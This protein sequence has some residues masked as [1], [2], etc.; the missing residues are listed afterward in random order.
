MLDYYEEYAP[1]KRIHIHG[2]SSI[3][4]PKDNTVLFIKEKYSK[5]ADNLL[6][7]SGC[8]IFCEKMNLPEHTIEKNKIVVCEL[9][10]KEFGRFL[11]DNH[12]EELPPTEYEL[13]NGAY[14]SKDAMIGKN[15][16]ILPM[17]FI[18]RDV[19]IGDNCKICA[20]VHILPN[21]IIEN[22]CIINDNVIIGNM[23]FAYEDG[24]RIP[25]LGGVRI[26]RDTVIGGQSVISRGA[27]ENTIIGNNVGI[28]SLCYVSHND[29]IGNN[30]LIVGGTVLFGSVMVGDGA[31]I[32]GNVTVRNGLTLGEKCTIGMG[33]VVTKNV[34]PNQIVA[35]NP[36]K[37]FTQKE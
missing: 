13:R 24:Q 20:G 34:A 23:D 19:Q 12:A 18:D 15:V 28:D 33:S 2:V 32:S 14:I 30:V 1:G 16:S 3:L 11:M 29:I 36:A 26:G 4:H 25:Q 10:R 7:V 21:T 35:G 27:I 6:N 17:A 37:P 9:P 8:L 22:N 31:F 5:Y